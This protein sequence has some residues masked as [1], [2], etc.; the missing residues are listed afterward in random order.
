MP[1]RVCSVLQTESVSVSYDTNYIFKSTGEN[2]AQKE[3]LENHKDLVLFCE[4]SSVASLL[5]VR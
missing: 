1:C 5:I 2:F 3:D 4:Q